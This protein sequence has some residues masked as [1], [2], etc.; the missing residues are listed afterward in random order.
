[1]RS[2]LLLGAGVVLPAKNYAKRL[3]VTNRM[4]QIEKCLA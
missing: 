4:D 2:R 3:D 1:V